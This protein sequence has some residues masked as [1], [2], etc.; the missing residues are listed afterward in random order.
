MSQYSFRH[1]Y[2]AGGATGRITWAVQRLILANAI[3]FAVQLVMMISFNVA[4]IV[5]QTLSFQPQAFFAGGVWKPFTYMFLHVNLMHLFFNMLWLYF[6]GP[7]VERVLSTRQFFRFYIFCGAVGV[8]GTIVPWL[9]W[10]HGA[11]VLGASGAVMGVLVAFAVL[12]PNREVFFFPFPLPV[13]ARGLVLVVIA[14]NPVTGAFEFGGVSVATHFGG[15]AA[16]YA[17]MKA[18]PILRHWGEMW[19][20]ARQ[21]KKAQKGPKDPAGEAVDNIFEFDKEKRRRKQ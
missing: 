9:L 20:N 11:Y 16:G 18:V 5:I 6:F 1:E 4:G 21:S 8:M 17:Y 3:V 7:E 2:R 19:Q 15:M 12:N 13:N 10:N 14:W